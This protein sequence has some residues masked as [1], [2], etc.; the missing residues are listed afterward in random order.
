M[1]LPLFQALDQLG[2]TVKDPLRIRRWAGGA[3]NRVFQLKETECCLALRLNHADIDRLG[4]NRLREKA[5][6][7]A[8]EGQAWAPTVLSITNE[9]LLTEWEEGQVP[10][11]GSETDLE[12]LAGALRSVH[13]IAVSATPLNV[14]HQIEHL[15]EQGPPL[16][17]AIASALRAHCEAYRL[18]RSL[19]LCHHDW[20]PGNLVVSDD[21][22][23]LLDW[24]FAALGDPAMDVAA[25]AQGFGLTDAQLEYLAAELGI[26]TQ[27]TQQARCLMEAVALLWYRANPSAATGSPPSAE[28]WYRR[29]G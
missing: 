8:I 4:V 6:L 16:E 11:S 9:W 17:S 12:W 13:S 29:W 28:D 3:C 24:E 22:W 18:P 19:A 1:S 25:A 7:E 10:A 14:A 20:H 23:V 5:V 21:R 26:S 2:N 27:R 15:Q